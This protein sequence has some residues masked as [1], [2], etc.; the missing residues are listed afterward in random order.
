MMVAGLDFSTKA[1]DVVLL[2][3]DEQT[4]AHFWSKVEKTDACWHWMGARDRH[5]YGSFQA[6]TRAHRFAYEL[7]R[8]PIPAG[9]EIDH[10]CRN[11]SCVNPEH[12][13]AVTHREN[14]RR[15]ENFAGRN[16]RKTHCKRG[17]ALTPDNVYV[18][19]SRKHSRS[20]REC[21]RLHASYW[22]PRRDR[23]TK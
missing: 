19:P 2:D 4:I 12:L 20:C 10:L 18:Q 8:G 13:E 17:H 5:G 21:R 6:R 14:M 23:R 16:A 15:A 3:V 9:L 22:N 7:A 11:P 1:L